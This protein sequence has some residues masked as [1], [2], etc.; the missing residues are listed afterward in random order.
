MILYFIPFFKKMQLLFIF[1]QLYKQKSPTRCAGKQFCAMRDMLGSMVAYAGSS[2]SSIGKVR[3]SSSVASRTLSLST[4]LEG[5][6]LAIMVSIMF[7]AWVL[8]IAST[9]RVTSSP[10]P[11]PEPWACP[12]NFFMTSPCY[13]IGNSCLRGFL[14][15]PIEIHPNESDEQDNTHN[16]NIR[17][18]CHSKLRVVG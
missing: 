4:S 17:K 8:S 16:K 9:Q 7:R 10:I 13:F 6:L 15:R 3:H 11:H 12:T 14:G 1:C 5:Y 2:G 18:E